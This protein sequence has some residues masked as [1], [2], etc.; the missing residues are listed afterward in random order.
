MIQV[1]GLFI[2]IYLLLFD[3]RGTNSKIAWIAVI[4]I[5][6]IIGTISFL[7][8]GRNPQERRFSA[9]QYNEMQ[10]VKTT[11]RSIQQESERQAPFLATRIERLTSSI[12]HTGNDVTI[13]TNGDKTFAAI[14]SE[15]KKATHHIH[16]QYYI[17]RQDEIGTQ[18]RN[19][20]VERAR[21]GVEV[22]FIYDDWG[23][24]LSKSFL[25][26]LIQAGAEVKAFDPVY[27]FWIARTANLRN[28]RKMIILDGQTAF[29][30]GLN[31]GEEYRSNTDDFKMWRDTHMQVEGPAVRTLQESFLV[32]WVYAQN[33]R[34]VADSF[35]SEE[36]I[37]QY[38][39]PV[40]K[41]KDWAQVVYGGPYD[42]ERL[43]RDAMLDLIDAA[44]HSVSIVSPYFVPDEE[45]LAVLRRV[46][47]SG[48]E[49]NVIIPGKGD[50]GISFHGSNAY[51]ETM[52]DAGANMYAYDEESFIHAKIM[53][54]DDEQAAVGT[55]NF[56]VRSFRLNH[57][58][59]VFLP[60]E[61]KAIAHLVKDFQTDVM[62]S[63]LY[64][65]RQMR[66]K[67]ILQRLKEQLS[68]LLSP[69]L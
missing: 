6:P 8:F 23:T 59:M 10:K 30:G 16:I 63:T 33:E 60:G 27:S 62:E 35:I 56:D 21:A 69:I 55:A 42:N 49:V 9:V 14:L 31:V 7:F 43:V 5:I 44:K 66:K 47:M 28:H 2:S 53:I 37:K 22:R 13:L 52:I 20:L 68:S 45:S 18:I 58:L 48:I 36:G 54:V 19:V 41:G 57:E 61:S 38:F 34:N 40:E 12:P 50:R 46:A 65:A 67:P 32:D 26:P 15:L 29:T 39:T 3:R 64:T 51:I 4:F 25:E 1:L 24:K 11:L 17:Y